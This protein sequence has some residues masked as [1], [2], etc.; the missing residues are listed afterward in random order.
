MFAAKYNVLRRESS[1]STVVGTVISLITLAII[2]RA[3]KIGS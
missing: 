3:L 2:M 1:S